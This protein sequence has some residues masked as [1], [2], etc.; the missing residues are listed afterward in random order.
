MK[1]FLFLL[2]LIAI[3]II[4]ACSND[5]DNNNPIDQ[6]PPATQT[7]KQT[8]GCLINGE[9]FIPTR[10]GGG[11]PRAFYQFVD[12]A[13]TLGISAS[14]GNAGPNFESINIGAL[15][16]SILEESTY[17]L[18]EFETGHFFGEYF[19]GGGLEISG[20]TTSTNPGS[21]IITK[22]DQENGI[23]AGTFEFTVLD[24]EGNEIKV[25]DG[26]FDLFY[27]SNVTVI[28]D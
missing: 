8:I 5:D 24:K 27:E 21:L 23:I 9:A 17:N 19:V 6:L 2:V 14:N 1:K 20:T 11:Q 28:S 16:I 7:G 25:T 26:R 10:F 15:D 3:T 12:G 18:K 13:F 22:F 4:S